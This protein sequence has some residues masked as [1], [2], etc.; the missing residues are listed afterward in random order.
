MPQQSIGPYRI[1]GKLGEGGMGEV[2]EAMHETIERRVAIKLLHPDRARD[3]EVAARFLNEA[4]AVNR[5]EHT[6]LVQ[7][8][9]CNQTS[10]GS[11]YIVMEL[12]R[13]PTLGQRL[14]ERGRLTPAEAVTMCRQISSALVAVH[15]QG[16]VHRD[17]KPENLMLVS[18]PE[19]PGRERVKI[20][21]FGI[22]KLTSD[23]DTGQV[24]TS[25]DVIIGTPRYM[26]P[27]QCR[28]NR[29][30]DD[31]SDV[32]SLGVVLYL[33][34]AGR[35]P[36]E[37][38]GSGEVIAMHIYEPVPP[39][40]RLAPETPPELIELCHRM[41]SKKKRARPTMRQ[42][43][44]EFETLAELLGPPPSTVSST[45]LPPPPPP[46]EPTEGA[47]E[48]TF[49]LGTGPNAEAVFEPTYSTLGV[50]TGQSGQAR[51]RPLGRWLTAGLATAASLGLL[52]LARWGT[53]PSPAPAPAL[54][55]RLTPTPA[56][57]PPTPPG[58]PPKL[59]RW[60]LRSQPPG[61][62][63]VRTADGVVL[64]RTPWTSEMATAPGQLE[65]R[66]RLP[67]FAERRLTLARSSEVSRDEILDAASPPPPKK[68]AQKSTARPKRA[69]HLA[70]SAKRV[71][72]GRIE[73]EE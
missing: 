26:S 2:F 23:S 12:L 38:S 33:M 1:I 57:G 19:T 60:S 24:K 42:V 7:I 50:S 30:I 52:L 56:P 3:R 70:P 54:P 6:G 46:A 69:A 28:G 44:T 62:E 14:K 43:L 55:A 65:L 17:L 45:S 11:I 71:P 16:I 47:T 61:A 5:I 67:G 59:V 15:E 4:R 25:S 40:R 18:D 27:E 36:F 37:G 32:Y 73:V 35:A 10:D 13:G 9:D 21:D 41:L 58:P 8:S 29:E 68:P 63:I 72:H 66:L 39:L 20:L 49:G 53:S 31:K 22:A 34:L 64:G 48:S 51:R